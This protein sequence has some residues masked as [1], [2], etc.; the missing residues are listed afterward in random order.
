MALTLQSALAGGRYSALHGR[1]FRELAAGGHGSFSALSA[2]DQEAPMDLSRSAA[3]RSPSPDVSITTGHNALL[4]RA[5]GPPPE[6]EP[7]DETPHDLRLVRPSHSIIPFHK[8]RKHAQKGS[9]ARLKRQR[10]EETVSLL[11]DREAADEPP[12]PSRADGEAAGRDEDGEPA[13][14]P[15]T[16]PP[17]PQLMQQMLMMQQQQ[18]TDPVAYPSLLYL[19][20]CAMMQSLQLQQALRHQHAGKLSPSAAACPPPRRPG[21]VSPASSSAGTPPAT[22]G[23]PGT[24]SSADE[25]PQRR[26]APRTL[27]G[28]HVR[29]GQGASPETLRTLRRVL[30]E[31]ARLRDLG[32]LPPPKPKPKGR[33]RK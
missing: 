8:L 13:P 4:D 12:P 7:L 25:P 9:R 17:P 1:T 15:P 2:A 22:P 27:T 3:R 10:L 26:R 20:Y 14:P 24:S 31:K 30:L 29:Q 19:Q 11:R 28:K 5:M 33:R 21:S 23:T 16:L 32:L 6:P 18:Q